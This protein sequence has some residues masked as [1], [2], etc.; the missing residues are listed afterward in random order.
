MSIQK[1]PEG[2][3]E[4]VTAQSPRLLRAAWL[5]TRDAHLAE[6][7]LQTALAV[8]WRRWSQI[9]RYDQPE[10]YVR[11]VLYTTYISWWR[12]RWRGETATASLPEL[13][14][15]GDH[16]TDITQRHALRDALGRLTRT[17]RAVIVLRFVE[18]QSVASTATTLGISESSV[19][20]HTSRGLARLR[21]DAGLLDPADQAGSLDFTGPSGPQTALI[22]L[23]LE[24]TR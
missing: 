10:A 16:T 1:P 18:D 6:D 8:T 23:A 11:R 13:F 20:V 21:L 14:E 7:L 4:F 15:P 24:G 22:D 9:V 2:F 12:R 17:Q 19:R 5:L 3:T